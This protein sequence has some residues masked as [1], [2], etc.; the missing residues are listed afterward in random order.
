MIGDD[1][2]NLLKM[3]NIILVLLI[4]LCSLSSYAW[5]DLNRDVIELDETYINKSHATLKQKAVTIFGKSYTVFVDKVK[6]SPT[7]FTAEIVIVPDNEHGDD[8][9]L[10]DHVVQ[11]CAIEDE[12][13]DTHG[14]TSECDVTLY[15]NY[16]F[17]IVSKVHLIKQQSS[18]GDVTVSYTLYDYGKDNTF[19]LDLVFPYM[20]NTITAID[21][22]SIE[23]NASIEYYDLQGRKLNGPQSGIVIEKQG[24]K[25]T[26]KLYR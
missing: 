18:F 7:W 22:M 2:I 16:D 5:N 8:I 25:V 3:R 21:K 14:Y 10:T 13:P 6:L 15:Q 11:S 24:N 12:T 9:Q 17:M 19:T 20:P 1:L 23:N 26:K 4:G